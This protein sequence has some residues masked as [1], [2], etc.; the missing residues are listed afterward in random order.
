ML[1]RVDWHRITICNCAIA[2]IKIIVTIVIFSITRALW[3]VFVPKS[4]SVFGLFLL[5]LHI[6]SNAD[7]SVAID[8]V[9]SCGGGIV[10]EKRRLFL[11]T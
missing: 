10:L 5:I 9:S 6:I 8:F 7:L 1:L 3:Q 4:T 11:I 2:W